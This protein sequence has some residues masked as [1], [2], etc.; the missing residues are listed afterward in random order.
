VTIEEGVL[1]RITAFAAG[2]MVDATAE[3]GATGFRDTGAV[4]TTSFE[5]FSNNQLVV[6]KD[7]QPLGNNRFRFTHNMSAQNPR[8]ML[9]LRVTAREGGA[10]S[11]VEDSKQSV[12]S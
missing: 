7:G 1:V 6:Q 10:S 11:R 9:R 8:P 12:C 5:L 4:I 3:A 2:C